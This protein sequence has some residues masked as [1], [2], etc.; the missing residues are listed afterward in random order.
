MMRH[1]FC[2]VFLALTLMGCDKR[3]AAQ[4]SKQGDSAHPLEMGSVTNLAATMTDE[5]ILRAMGYDPDTLTSHRDN[6]KDGYSTIYSN[7]TILVFVTR[8]LVSGVT[9]LRMRPEGQKQEWLL[10][11]P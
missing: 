1:F 8:S 5:Q 9:V 4:P 6:G 10:G 11:K 7:E 2:I 3:F